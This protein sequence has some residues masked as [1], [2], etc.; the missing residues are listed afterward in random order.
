MSSR[1]KT[2]KEH[3]TTLRFTTEMWEQ[4]TVAAAALDVSVAQYVRDAARTRLEQESHRARRSGEVRE[5]SAKAK[6]RSLAEAESSL[7]LWEQGRLARQ[8][9]QALREDSRV[10]REA[11]KAGRGSVTVPGRLIGHWQGSRLAR[12]RLAL[13]PE[14]ERTK[15]SNR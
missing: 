12:E 8:R 6:D 4:L 10:R 2:P 14:S 13:G 11:G 1:V 15:P 5:E 7:A 9:A 3:Q